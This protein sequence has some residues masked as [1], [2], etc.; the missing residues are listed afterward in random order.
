MNAQNMDKDAGQIAVSDA[1]PD[2]TPKPRRPIPSSKSSKPPGKSKQDHLVALLSKPNGVR[3]SVISDRLGRQAHT[4]R[5]AI[6]GLR[7]RGH[8][9]MTSKSPKTGETVYVIHVAPK[10]NGSDP[11]EAS[12]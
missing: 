6:S 12:S 5:A 2:R 8:G 4:V 9:V 7:K 11:V 3:V 1:A 10:E